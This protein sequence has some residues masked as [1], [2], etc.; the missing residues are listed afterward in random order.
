VESFQAN[1]FGDGPIVTQKSVPASGGHPLAD[2]ISFD[3]QK[4][5]LGVRSER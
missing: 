3:S 1:T 4:I 2:P 5:D